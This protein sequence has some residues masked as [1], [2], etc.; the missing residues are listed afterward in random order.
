MSNPKEDLDRIYHCAKNQ[1]P[2]WF[3]SGMRVWKEI[4]MIEDKL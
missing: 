4:P 1:D 3:G 2:M